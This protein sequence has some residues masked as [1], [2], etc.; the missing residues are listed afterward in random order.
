MLSEFGKYSLTKLDEWTSVLH[1]ASKWGFESICSLAL[2]EVLPLASP[3]DKIV[4]G[5][6]YGFVDCLTPAFVAVCARA[7]PLSLAEAEKMSN[8][9]VTR[10]FQARERARSSSASVDSAKAQEAVACIFG[11]GDETVVA[12]NADVDASSFPSALRDLKLQTETLSYEDQLSENLPAVSPV[13]IEEVDDGLMDAFSAW[14][15]VCARL[16]ELGFDTSPKDP[17]YVGSKKAVT[18]AS[19]YA[20]Y[21]TDYERILAYVGS[22]QFRE[23]SLRH[24]LSMMLRR[25]SYSKRPRLYVQFWKELRDRMDTNSN[26]NNGVLITGPLRTAHFDRVLGE[27]CLEFVSHECALANT[28]S[29][30]FISRQ[31]PARLVSN[32][33]TAGLL[34]DKILRACFIHISPPPKQLGLTESHLM[35]LLALLQNS[36]KGL[37]SACCRDLMDNIFAKL[38]GYS[39]EWKFASLH[40]EI[41]VSAFSTKVT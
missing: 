40:Q 41:V 14:S 19:N 12:S 18:L 13:R 9:D 34:N 4:L 10:I 30:P 16:D 29:N 21:R 11:E 20:Q 3:V 7:E 38:R 2:R 28:H 15:R 31:P 37:D 25:C 6:K 33:A 17:L 39:S 36:G 22:P 26:C 1:L 27:Q 35:H 23:T 8:A 24:F 5:R 32:L